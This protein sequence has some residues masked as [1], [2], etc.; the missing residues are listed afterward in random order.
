MLELFCFKFGSVLW[1]FLYLICW[2]IWTI[3]LIQI[4]FKISC[5][6]FMWTTYELLIRV[7]CS[8]LIATWLASVITTLLACCLVDILEESTTFAFPCWLIG[9]D[10][11]EWKSDTT[12]LCILSAV[13]TF[14]IWTRSM[15]ELVLY[16][17]PIISRFCCSD[18]I[19]GQITAIFLRIVQNV[20]QAWNFTE[21]TFRHSLTILVD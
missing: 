6:S 13:S 14:S 19:V 20:I 11:Y 9:K 2:P 5:W 15:T 4:F 17:S 18:F 1:T 7:V 8:F 12:T 21:L 10:G 16:T 3:D